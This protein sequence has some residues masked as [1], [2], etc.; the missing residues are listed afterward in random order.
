MS[1][2]LLRDMLI[3]DLDIGV[4]SVRGNTMILLYGLRLPGSSRR[5]SWSISD[6][7]KTIELSS[8][9]EL[10]SRIQVID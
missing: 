1:Q 10:T 9:L 8:T 6:I 5:M 7:N 4:F 2:G 3:V